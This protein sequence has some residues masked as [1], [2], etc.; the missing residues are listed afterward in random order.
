MRYG[1]YCRENNC[2]WFDENREICTSPNDMHGNKCDFDNG[3]LPG[4]D[5]D[6]I[7]LKMV[8]WDGDLTQFLVEANTNVE[9]I[10]KAMESNFSIGKVDDEIVDDMKDSSAYIVEDVDFNLLK[11][12][13]ERADCLGIYGEAVVFN[14]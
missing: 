11:E 4:W 6:G 5:D 10:K 14:D 7:K 9:A 1:S 3:I 2:P 8:T 12:I 13:F